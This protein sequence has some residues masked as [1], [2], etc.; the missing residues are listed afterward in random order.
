VQQFP[1]SYLRKGIFWERGGRKK[2]TA[3]E[4][5]ALPPLVLLS[6]SLSAI[7]MEIVKTPLLPLIFTTYLF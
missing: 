5:I 3:Y 7:Y 2:K 4:D 6:L 1:E